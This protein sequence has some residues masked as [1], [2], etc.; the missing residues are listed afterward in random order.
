MHYAIHGHTAAEH[1]LERA[2]HQKQNMGLMTWQ[3]A[4]D[5]KIKRVM[6]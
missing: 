3:D 6:S 2:D 5:G 1:I 4:P